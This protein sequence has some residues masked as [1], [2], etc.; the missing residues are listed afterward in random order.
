MKNK[1][2]KHVSWLESRYPNMAYFTAAIGWIELGYD[3]DSRRSSFII[4]LDPGGLVWEGRDRYESLDE[5]FQD[6][7]ESLGDW[8]REAGIEPRSE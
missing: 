6:L 5:A 7:E 8:M 2:E 1:K 4:A 3:V